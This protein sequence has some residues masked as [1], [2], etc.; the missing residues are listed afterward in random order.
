MLNNAHQECATESGIEEDVIKKTFAGDL[1]EDEK[2]KKHVLCVNRKLGF[3]NDDGE[4]QVE[5]IRKT[6]GEDIDNVDELVEKCTVD[7]GS[8]E[9]TA[10]SFAKC[11]AEFAPI[12]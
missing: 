11:A 6:I 1:V 3:F 5:V 9:D 12:H 4:I 2:L 7:K 8:P 10:F